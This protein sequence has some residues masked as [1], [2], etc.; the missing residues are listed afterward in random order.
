MTIEHAGRKSGPLETDKSNEL[1]PETLSQIRALS[2]ADQPLKTAE[3]TETGENGSAES[4]YVLTDRVLPDECKAHPESF[5]KTITP[6]GVDN[7]EDA[8][9]AGRAAHAPK[10]PGA[11]EQLVE[12]AV[13]SPPEI[14]QSPAEQAKI[15][16]RVPSRMRS[17]LRIYFLRMKLVLRTAFRN[18]EHVT[19]RHLAVVAIVTG[20][21]LEPW[22]VPFFLTVFALL[23]GLVWLVLGTDRVMEFAER[24]WQKYRTRKPA[25]AELLRV[26]IMRYRDHTQRWVDRL[27]ESWARHMH[28]P[29][30]QSVQKE[31]EAET[32]FAS[33]L[34]RMQ[35]DE[36]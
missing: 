25:D 33:R 13:S 17:F 28:L 8:R 21:L 12:Q 9:S 23:A 3:I 24:I 16:G 29:H 10:A 34:L 30:W 18:L 32:V 4:V 1:S 22:A 11:L 5:P 7:R 19:P 14:K 35:R 27:P 31:E 15:I 36:R 26:K 20:F 2:S 6:E